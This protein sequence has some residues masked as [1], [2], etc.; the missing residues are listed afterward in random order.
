MIQHL[1]GDHLAFEGGVGAAGSG[2]LS[3]R[4][5]ADGTLADLQDV[6]ADCRGGQTSFATDPQGRA[7]AILHTSL[8]GY[9][10]ARQVP[11]TPAA[12]KCTP[13]PPVTVTE[14][15]AQT[16]SWSPPPAETASSKLKIAVRRG[17][18]RTVL[19][20]LLLEPVAGKISATAKLTI[21]GRR[22]RVARRTGWT[23]GALSIRLGKADWKALLRRGGTVRVTAAQRNK[24]LWNRWTV[25]RRV[26]KA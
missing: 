23:P 8:N 20:G 26:A 6:T 12:A 15:P 1:S 13:P 19:V 7:G 17:P 5:A 4:I 24:K 22:A 3:A 16:P 14:P 10:L 2:P 11:G 25:S 9:A 21:P 18:K